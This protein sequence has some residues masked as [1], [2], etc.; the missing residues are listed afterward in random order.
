MDARLRRE[1][2]AIASDARSSATELLERGLQVLRAAAEAGPDALAAAANE[3][4]RAQPA[5]AGLRT[6]AALAVGATDPAAALDEFAAR[7]ERAPSQIARHAVG[8]LALRSR[9]GPL[10]LVT[11]SKSRPVEE[12]IRLAAREQAL[13]VSCAESRP[14]KEGRDLARALADA[15]IQVDLYSD[16]AI[17]AVIPAADAVLVGADALGAH[18]FVNKAGTGAVCALAAASGIP[19]YVLA[20]REKILPDDV[21]RALPLRGGSPH[22]VWR[23]PGAGIQVKNPY[24][25]VVPL[26]YVTAVVTEGGVMQTTEVPAGALWR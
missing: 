16:A 15:H 13:L 4:V 12:A 20:G 21:F 11:C 1:I 25:E 19:A 22:E 9:I 23:D 26:S 10:H 6:A 17:S 18:A 2:R 7:V 3:L 14:A 8:L 24:F 5:M